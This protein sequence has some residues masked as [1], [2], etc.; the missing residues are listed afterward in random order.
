MQEERAEREK[1]NGANYDKEGNQEDHC[2][3]TTFV[4]KL[5]LIEKVIILFFFF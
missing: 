5:H 4:F 3:V 1:D 2:R